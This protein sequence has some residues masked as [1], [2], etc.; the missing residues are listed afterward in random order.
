MTMGVV[1]PEPFQVHLCIGR[2]KWEIYSIVLGKKN[3]CPS[4]YLWCKK[5]YPTGR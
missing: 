2:E 4:M 5:V 3:M 1:E